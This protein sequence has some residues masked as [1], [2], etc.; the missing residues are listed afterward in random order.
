[1][2][3]D[4]KIKKLKKDAIVPEQA[5]TGSAG[6]D[7]RAYIL[8][9]ESYPWRGESIVPYIQIEPNQKVRVNTALAFQLPL[10]HVMIIAPRSSSGIKKGLMLQN[11]IG[12]LDADYRGECFLFIKNIGTETVTIEHNER[13]A[14]A[15][16]LPYPTVNFNV[17]EELDETE[18]GEGGF[19]STGRL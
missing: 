11:T 14:Q 8:A 15:V 9:E 10:N 19:G 6:F 17:V 7:L 3:I 2:N 4:V 12:V 13:I 5:T 16:I 18:R 1:M